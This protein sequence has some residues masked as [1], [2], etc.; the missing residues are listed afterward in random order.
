MYAYENKQATTDNISLCIS[1]KASRKFINLF[2]S[3]PS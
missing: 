1:G 3:F 2:P